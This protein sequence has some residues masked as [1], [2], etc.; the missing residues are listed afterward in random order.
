MRRW[1]WWWLSPLCMAILCPPWCSHWRGGNIHNKVMASLVD[2]LVLK[3]LMWNLISLVNYSLHPTL[4]SPPSQFGAPPNAS[5]SLKSQKYKILQFPRRICNKWLWIHWRVGKGEI[6]ERDY[7]V[8]LE[9]CFTPLHLCHTRKQ[10]TPLFRP[11][12]TTRICS[13]RALNNFSILGTMS[14]YLNLSALIHVSLKSWNSQGLTLWDRG[15]IFYS[16]WCIHV[17]KMITL[18]SWLYIYGFRIHK[19]FKNCVFG[20][21][22]HILIL[23]DVLTRAVNLDI[24]HLSAR[25]S[26]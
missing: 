23:L 15:F 8:L 18:L 11:M 25:R 19:Y 12:S 26:V 3:L 24:P 20:S 5:Q 16:H 10:W 4:L 22:T 21:V 7:L 13:L 6:W 1:L 14:L 17:P 2:L 9:H